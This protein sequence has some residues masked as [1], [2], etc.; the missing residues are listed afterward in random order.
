MLK[1]RVL[2][3]D[4]SMFMR[5]LISELINQ[6]PLLEVVGI[7][8]NG[9]EAME[10][11]K[12]LK[13]DVITMD[14]EMPKMD[15]L[16]ALEQ[17]MKNFPTP[18]LMVSSL[19][20]KG[21]YET[22]KALQLGAVDFIQ[23]PSGSISVDMFRVRDEL[24]TKV[25]AVAKA[26]LSKDRPKRRFAPAKKIKKDPI[27]HPGPVNTTFNQIFAIGTSTGGPK[28]LETVITELPPDFHCPVLVVQHM[29]PKFTHYLAKRL[30]DISNVTV[31]E[32]ENNEI[33][34]GGTVYI[35]PGD[36]HMEVR[37]TINGYR[38]VLNK[39]PQRNGHRPSVDVLFDSVSKLKKLKR[40]YIIMTGMGSDGAKGMQKG[41]EEGAATTIAESEKTCVVY[42]MPKS[43]VQLGC[44]DHIMPVDRI[45]A[46]MVEL[47]KA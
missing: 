13:P 29:P 11:T 30:N 41:K 8:K 14:I 16:S 21:A 43:A 26:P 39:E 27:L 15:G 42:G 3:V 2:V 35:A 4:D 22:I 40:H 7:A 46:K 38:I 19:T 20:D 9:L 33:I 28:A 32:A 5:K 23:K 44:V 24:L 34:R 1:I 36:Y 37:Q 17:I 47:A 31:T 25:K 18:T 12:E 45:S 6:D 10:L